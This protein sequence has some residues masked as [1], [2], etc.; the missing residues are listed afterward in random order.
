[1]KIVRLLS[2]LLFAVICIGLSSCNDEEQVA[3]LQVTNYLTGKWGLIHTSGWEYNNIGV[4][5]DWDKDDSGFFYTFK[6]D[7]SGYKGE[8]LKYYF[9][10]EV[11]DNKLLLIDDNTAYFENDFFNYYTIKSVT[12]NTLILDWEDYDIHGVSIGRGTDTFNRI[13]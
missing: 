12:S 7:G 4:K 9:E 11:N 13:Y 1:M 10:W 2:L 5:V 8:S 6:K 3:D